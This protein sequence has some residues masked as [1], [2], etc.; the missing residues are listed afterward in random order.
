MN[1]FH[2]HII[3]NIEFCLASVL[4]SALS[5]NPIK[6]RFNSQWF[7]ICFLGEFLELL[8]QVIDGTE[9]Y[10]S[11]NTDVAF[12]NYSFVFL[13][14]NHM[15]EVPLE[16]KMLSQ[17]DLHLHSANADK[18]SGWVTELCF[19]VLRTKKKGFEKISE[20]RET[21][22]YPYYITASKVKCQI[23]CCSAIQIYCSFS[24]SARMEDQ[25]LP[26]S[27]QMKRLLNC[28]EVIFIFL[29]VLCI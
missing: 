19:K 9:F 12:G 22:Q 25:S 23:Y 5:G 21:H 1:F 13:V 20:S 16:D 11:R 2:T 26:L 6:P 24:P 29:R 27:S 14:V 4:C 7:L 17:V 15:T 3:V 10:C 8:V 28:M 18:M